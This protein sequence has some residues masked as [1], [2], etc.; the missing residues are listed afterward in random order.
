[1]RAFLK[2]WLKRLL[3]W[4]A[5]GLI[6]LVLLICVV[7]AGL[8][9]TRPGR[10][11]VQSEVLKL[12]NGSVFASELGVGELDRI[13]PQLVLRDATL[14]DED[15]FPMAAVARIE[16]D[17]QL[18]PLLRQHVQL[19]RVEV[20]GAD[21]RLRIREDGT[22]N[23]SGMMQESEPKPEPTGPG[24]TV[25][26]GAIELR[27]SEASLRDAR[28]ED[29]RLLALASLQA[30]LAL[31][32]A[33]EVEI[34]LSTLH[35]LLGHPLDLAADVPVSLNE[36]TLALGAG[37]IGF[38]TTG[39]RFGETTFEDIR[40][41]LESSATG[42]TPFDRIEVDI[43]TIDL[44]PEDVAPFLGGTELLAPLVIAANIEGPVDAVLLDLPIHG[45]AGT[46][47]LSLTFDLSD[48]AQPKYNGLARVVRFRPAE[49][50]NIDLDADVS[51]AIYLDGENFTPQD[52]TVAARVEVGPSQVMGYPVELAY[53]SAS[54]AD[55]EL[56]FPRL[57]VA[58][59]G[60]S[61][62][63]AASVDLDGSFSVDVDIDAPDLAQLSAVLPDALAEIS[64]SVQLGVDVEGS[65]PLE[66]LQ[67]GT[68]P[69]P[70]RLL[71]WAGA[72]G[73]SGALTVRS[74]ALGDIA[75]GSADLEFAAT[76]TDGMPDLAVGLEGSAITVAGTTIDSV[77]LQGAFD[78]ENVE[79]R[80]DVQ[81]SELRASY[82]LRGRLDDDRL[83]VNINSLAAQV[84]DI[85]VE[86]LEGARLVAAL[87][88]NMAP[89]T[90]TL[91]P[92]SIRVLDIPVLVD[93]WFRLED[94]ALTATVA[95]QNIEIEPL[96]DRFAPDIDV[97]GRVELRR[98]HVAGTLSRPEVDVDAR[99]SDL[100]VLGLAPY[101]VGIDL[102]YDSRAVRGAVGVTSRQARVAWLELGS[103]G[104][105]LE[106][107]LST[108]RFGLGMD[109][110][111]DLVAGVER[112]KFGELTP[113]LPEGV[114][115]ATRGYIALEVAASGT[116]NEPNVDGAL[117]L[118]D[119]TFE[120]PF[121]EETW[122]VTDANLNLD[123][124][125]DSVGER[126]NLEVEVLGALG[127]RDILDSRISASFDLDEFLANP[128]DTLSELGV[129]ADGQLRGLTVAD[130]PPSLLE[131][132]GL[133]SGLLEADF[134][135]DG[136]LRSGSGRVELV[137]IDVTVEGQPPIS[138]HVLASTDARTAID[139]AVWLGADG[140]SPMVE[141]P[142]GIRPSEGATERS[143][144]DSRLYATLSGSVA[145]PAITLVDA[146]GL[147]AAQVALRLTIPESPVSS[148]SEFMELPD[149]ARGSLAGYLDLF[150]TTNA[151]EAFG[152]VALRDVDLVGGAE[153]TVGVQV[154]YNNGLAD[155]GLV[156]CDGAGEGVTADASVLVP[157]DLPSLQAG[158]PPVSSWPI[159]AN[160]FAHTDLSAVAPTL[161]AGSLVDA[162]GGLLDV[163][164]EVNGLI[165]S[166][167]V[168][169]HAEISE[170]RIGFIPLARLFENVEVDLQFSSDGVE[171]VSLR[172][173]DE[174]GTVRGSGAIALESFE[175]RSFDFSMRSRDFL[176]LDASGLTV[177]TTGTVDFSGN[178]DG[179]RID[180]DVQLSGIEV[181]A[182]LGSGGAGPTRRA[183]WVYVVDED[184][185][186]EQV[187]ER[188]PI[189]ISEQAAA[190]R[191]APPMEISLSIE[192]VDPGVVRH[193]FGYVDFEVDLAIELGEEVTLDGIVALPS[194]INRVFGNTFEYRRGEIRFAADDVGIDP[195]IDVL[196]VHELSSDVTE[197]LTE[198]VGSAQEDR[199]TI[200]IPVVGR[201]SELAADDWQLSL[202]AD[203]QMSESDTLSVLV[204]GRLGSDTDAESQQG[205]QALAQLAL[206]FLGDQFSGGAIDTLSIESTGESA[207]V[208]GGKYIADNV[209]V[210]GTYIRSPDDDDDNN[211]EVSIEW[212]LRR[213]G[214]G[215]LR[216]ELRGGDQAKG[217]LELLY[218]LRRMAR[219]RPED[220]RADTT[221]EAGD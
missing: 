120:I 105:P 119:A 145:G 178:I 118:H 50:L 177:F 62:V 126:S 72:I 114:R 190:A 100:E 141:G 183:G 21:V 41:S 33:E 4:G 49:W 63:G 13:W 156:V 102:N 58:S 108:G 157:L 28:N 6:L 14:I 182:D 216:L 3:K 25:S 154:A 186:P 30:D 53:F 84:A 128:G 166:P 151:P 174:R 192:T 103:H 124:A 148:L 193:Q 92:V 115:L 40:G 46:I 163:E 107:D 52:A 29:A 27:D 7:F 34:E 65:L 32:V 37:T 5:V 153:G 93:A 48:P 189:R 149:G 20:T 22:L 212:I 97:S 12:L 69:T 205:T 76:A 206:G 47:E 200:Q 82:D 79:A 211:F 117:H 75:V 106:V 171:L 173:D 15:E 215:S 83:T 89:L 94:Q 136:D 54:Y 55:G 147:G 146:E 71:E 164:L 123:L 112:L 87:D 121:G 210:S 180:G 167:E 38:S 181:G 135:W 214:A 175:P 104:F 90:V 184:V 19:D 91:S 132:T 113:L 179:Q 73:G 155:V 67:A 129:Q 138:A 95:A 109:R 1:M 101:D 24:W 11:L 221:V 122:R 61:V 74:F 88:E 31:S 130:A 185:F 165:G 176:L 56:N 70:E 188:D 64:G 42:E 35:G 198:R 17:Y 209:Y 159:R 204:Q 26:L 194:G 85:D 18:L 99:V 219:E 220:A 80:G 208:E 150:G 140:I 86:L 98:L 125:H 9:Q 44:Q 59:M 201:L 144:F 168:V 45:P 218:N 196:V 197:Y 172:V 66:E 36:V 191:N 110:P 170:A 213:I 217:G 2:K 127:G 134:R 143:E 8:T 133:E 152:R 81:M 78:G 39:I 195:L 169:G 142:E 202:R 16:V 77:D 137:G 207:R 160:V 60:S 10:T 131:A 139:A 199:A 96:A 161:L 203:P 162:L 68:E 23:L 51:A 43:P 187:G 158:L 116:P 111:M 57:N